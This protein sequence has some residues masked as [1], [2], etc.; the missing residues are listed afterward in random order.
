ML[1]IPIPTILGAS[2]SGNL[3][4]LNSLIT[5]GA[6]VNGRNRNGTTPLMIAAAYGHDRAVD[7]LIEKGANVN[8]ANE[9]GTTP[10]MFAV[11]GG[12]VRCVRSLILAGADLTLCDGAGMTALT[13]ADAQRRPYISRVLTQARDQTPVVA[14]DA[15]Y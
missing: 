12:N 8:C 10:L 6:N 13:L 15:S 14:A 5:E 2:R 1:K 7:L 11:R 9:E 4:T 3:L